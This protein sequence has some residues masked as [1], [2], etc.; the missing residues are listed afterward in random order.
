MGLSISN[1]AAT[2]VANRLITKANT[3]GQTRLT[4]SGVATATDTTAG[5]WVQVTASTSAEYV[6]SGIDVS[7]T[8]S[9]AAGSLGRL[10][11]PIVYEIG[12][13]GAGSEVVIG[14]T[15][16]GA[17]SYDGS[18]PFL[19]DNAVFPIGLRITSG[20][21]LAVRATKTAANV[22]TAVTTAVG[23]HLTPYLNMEGN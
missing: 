21:R 17:I 6:L 5:S 14:T 10:D 19:R 23:V 9:L 3:A 2:A 13:G 15:A 18:A 7:G 22:A 4:A 16:L 12:I 11:T 1:V 20:T 8:V